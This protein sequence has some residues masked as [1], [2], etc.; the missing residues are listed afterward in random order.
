[1]TI[2]NDQVWSL[3]IRFCKVLLHKLA[4]D[5]FSPTFSEINNYKVAFEIIIQIQNTAIV[6]YHGGHQI[7]IH[8]SYVFHWQNATKRILRRCHSLGLLT[9][10][11]WKDKQTCW[12]VG[13][14]QNQ[15][16]SIRTSFNPKWLKRTNILNLNL[17]WS[18]F[19][20]HA[21]FCNN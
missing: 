18:V 4:T 1:M 19:A 17:H 12:V 2:R 7:M 14:Y 9:R 10:R 11:M 15:L 16:E 3:Q 8:V 13:G 20:W 21:I 6:R 5:C